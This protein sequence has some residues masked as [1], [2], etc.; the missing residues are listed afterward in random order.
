MLT[1]RDLERL[2]ALEEN[3]VLSVY[4]HTDPAED[5]KASHR[6]WLKDALKGLAERVPGDE[7]KRFHERV[8][9]ALAHVRDHRPQ[10]KSWVAFLGANTEEAFDLRVPVENEVH[11]GHPEL[12]QLL[13]LLEEYPPYAV[14]WADSEHLRFFVVAMHEIRELDE[15]ALELDTHDWRRKDLTPPGQPHG[16]AVRGAVRGGNQR[17]AFEGRVQAHVE[18]FW[19]QAQEVLR[20]LREEQG[21]EGFLLAG[22]KAVRDRFLQTLGPEARRLIGQISLPREAGLNDVLEA[23]TQAIQAHE[24]A[25]EEKLV[26]ALLLRASTSEKAGVGLPATLQALQEGRVEKVIVNR[27]LEEPLKECADCGHVYLPDGE[28]CPRCAS[29]EHRETSLRAMLPI[30]AHRHGAEVE[31]IRAPAAERLAPHGGIGA[32]WRY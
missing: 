8:E 30:L 20:R 29:P 26:D 24:R 22:P 21:V 13:W 27:R 1:R 19:R 32:L 4:L 23:S 17:D 12:T 7:R 6:I 11:W 9:R 28:G 3:P 16:S 25:Q 15:R 2:L 31:V 10:G 18:R 5:P 14:I